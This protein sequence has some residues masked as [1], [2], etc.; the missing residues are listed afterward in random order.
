MSWATAYIEKLQAGAAVQFRPRGHSMTGRVNDG[1]LVTV[2]PV[3]I[4]ALEV[5]D[6]VLCKVHGKQYLHLVKALR[7]PKWSRTVQIGNNKGY[8]NGWTT[9]VYGRLMKVED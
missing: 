7:G 2:G 4:S 8:V 9:Q 3:E 6:V 1:Q 5:G